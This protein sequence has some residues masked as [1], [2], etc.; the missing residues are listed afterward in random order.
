M[1]QLLLVV[2][3]LHVQNIVFLA[4][5]YLCPWKQPLTNTIYLED[6]PLCKV[7]LLRAISLST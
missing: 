2:L 7:M 3:A 1:N 5:C 6:K 4:S